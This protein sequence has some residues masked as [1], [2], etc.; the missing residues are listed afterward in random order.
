MKGM[1]DPAGGRHDAEPETETEYAAELGKPVPPAPP[2]DRS[3]RRI[4]WARRMRSAHAS[5]TIFRS[6]GIGMAGLVIILF[7]ALVAICAPLLFSKTGTLETQAVYPQNA[8]PAGAYPFGTDG[9]GRSVLTMVVWGARI[10]LTVGLTATL[11]AL[12]I[13]SA[14]GMSAGYFLGR[15]DAVLMRFT[16]WFLVIPW[17]GLALVLAVILGPGIGSIILVIAITSW[18][19]PA[20]V[21]RA[22]ALAVSARPYVERARAIGSRDTHIITHHILPNCMPIILTQLVLTAASA[23]YTESLLSFIGFG[24]PNAVSWGTMLDSAFSGGALTA[25]YW[26]QIVFP[27]ACIVLTILA[28]VMIGYAFDQVLNPRL[29]DR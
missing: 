13:G 7:F 11:I 28:L 12:V 18:P 29:R 19:F 8:A 14:V 24:D 4:A 16:E 1:I 22:Q 25:G 2:S 20:A 3:P 10:S 9:A 23:I 26:W 27:G 21:I 5:W 17:L 6:S 15:V